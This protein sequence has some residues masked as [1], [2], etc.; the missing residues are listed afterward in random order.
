MDPSTLTQTTSEPSGGLAPNI[1]IYLMLIGNNLNSWNIYMI[2]YMYNVYNVYNV[3][4]V[5]N[6]YNV[7]NIINVYIHN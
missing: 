7:Y 3:C 5:Y 2:Y 1:D 6:A 4:N